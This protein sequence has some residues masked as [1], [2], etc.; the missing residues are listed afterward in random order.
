MANNN[1]YKQLNNAKKNRKDEF[2]TRLEDIALELKNYRKEFKDKVVFCNCDDPYESN[3]FKYFAMNF[4]FLG[5]KKLIATCYSPSP[6]AYTQLSLFDEISNNDTSTPAKPAYKVVITEVPDINGSGSTDLSDV[7][8]LI[9]NDANVLSKLDGDGDFLSPECLK[10]LDEADIVV[11][12]PPF[13][14]YIPFFT[15][16]MEH[17]K[18]FL[19]I[20]NTLSLGYKEI[21][22]Y[23]MR[24]EVR[25]GYTNFNTG[26]FFEVPDY[27]EDFHH[28]DENTGKKIARVSGSCWITNLP[29]VNHNEELIC[30][31]EYHEGDY[32]KYDNLDA[33]HVETYIDIPK[34][35]DGLIGVPLTFLDKF[36]PDQFEIVGIGS[37]NLAKAIGVQ[38]N[39]RGRTDLAYH[40][41][42]GT[43]KCAFGRVII[44]RKKHE[45]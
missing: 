16:L 42:D 29:V 37:G 38:K 27:Y 44:R 32:I 15:T 5:L 13:S 35:Y 39:Y 9:E 1:S 40:L 21:F 28:I 26:M 20:C 36:N 7:Q 17:K 33:I 11:T 3:F 8:Y 23:F 12:N 19:L 10:L 41:P 45:D 31:R 18:K 24:D 2:Y 30:T 6:I 4:N 34:D 25:T 43:N 14:K 22:P